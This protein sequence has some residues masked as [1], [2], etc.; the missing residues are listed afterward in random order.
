MIE[1]TGPL[2]QANGKVHRQIRP[3]VNAN[4]VKFSRDWPIV[5]VASV[6][7]PDVDNDVIDLSGIAIPP[8]GVPLLSKHDK[9]VRLG[10]AHEFRIEMVYTDEGK[11]LGL[12][13]GGEWDESKFDAMLAKAA[14]R[15]GDIF[16]SVGVEHPRNMALE[17]PTGGRKI[18]KSSL[19]EIS[20]SDRVVNRWSGCPKLVTDPAEQLALGLY[21]PGESPRELND[22]ASMWRRIC[23]AAVTTEED[24]D[25]DFDDEA[26]DFDLDNDAEDSLDEDE[27]EDDEE[28]DLDDEED[29]DDLDTAWC[30]D[31]TEASPWG[32]TFDWRTW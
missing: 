29:G 7:L 12:I 11:A 2:V 9:D 19:V 3:L 25:D 30:Y 23:D 21:I 15:T 5:G 28:D 26:E 6:E 4:R 27:D 17:R 10:W 20:V 18:L 32:K 31:S 13:F 16:F 22:F 8:E 14:A 1:F 24:D